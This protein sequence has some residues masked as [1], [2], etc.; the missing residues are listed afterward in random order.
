MLYFYLDM[1]VCMIMNLR[2]FVLVLLFIVGLNDIL[3]YA[4]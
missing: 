2:N 3:S 4:I 1:G